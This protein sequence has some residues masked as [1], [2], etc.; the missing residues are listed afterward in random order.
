MKVNETCLF[1]YFNNSFNQYSWTP[2]MFGNRDSKL[3]KLFLF[4][5]ALSN[6]QLLQRLF[7]FFPCDR[8][9]HLDRYFSV[10]LCLHVTF[11]GYKVWF[12]CRCCR[13]G[14]QELSKHFYDL[15][16]WCFLDCTQMI[17]R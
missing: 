13:L 1:A 9:S 6:N 7:F 2:T 11:Q 12:P 15:N 5:K 3:S 17:W 8:Y 16:S 14:T 10:A 4:Y